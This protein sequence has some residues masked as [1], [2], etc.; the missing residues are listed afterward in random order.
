M[1]AKFPGEAPVVY[2]EKSTA[3]DV[4]DSL[5]WD[6]ADANQAKAEIIAIAA[7]VGVDEDEAEASHDYKIRALEGRKQASTGS[8]TLTAGT[9]T[10][11]NDETVGPTSCV[12]V[13]GTSAGFEGLSPRPYV[14]AVAEGSFT[15][16]HGTAAGTESFAWVAIA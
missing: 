2:G 13:Q 14:S 4:G 11:V 10:T 9:T 6:G 7:K 15:L 1:G 12:M 3:N 5:H 8:G 16:T